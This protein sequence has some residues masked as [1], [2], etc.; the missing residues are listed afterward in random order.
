MEEEPNSGKIPL[1]PR[2]SKSNQGGAQPHADSRSDRLWVPP[3]IQEEGI[4]LNP[5]PARKKSGMPTRESLAA[6]GERFA[7]RPHS[8]KKRRDPRKR[9]IVLVFVVVLVAF[10]AGMR[11]GSKPQGMAPFAPVALN[12]D[13]AVALEKYLREL[14]TGNAMDALNGMLAIEERNPE[15]PS[16]AYL[17]S[18][19][20]LKAGNVT[21]AE[22][23]AL[24]SI[25]K[26]ERV[27]D[28]LALLAVVDPGKSGTRLGDPNVRVEEWL[29]KAALA[30]P[31]NPRPPLELAGVLRLQ[32]RNDEARSSLEASRARLTP[33][34]S[35]AAVLTTLALL[36]LEETPDDNLP[37][38]IRVRP[39]PTSLFASAY[40]QMRKGNHASAA[41]ILR[42]AKDQ[43]PEQIFQYLLGDPA[44]RKFDRFPEY[45]GLF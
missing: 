14:R 36:D 16:L 44:L 13:D 2:K 3:G 39:D 1:R 42:E 10:L 4:H 27:S 24:E 45:D 43:M 23:K 18:L 7:S 25:A 31:A 38:S 21:L 9:L 37:V 12:G 6:S 17:S 41:A 20:A 28:S 15:T 5:D 33:V 26:R 30:D 22:E 11:L 8:A 29:Q 34:D 40:L 32:R 19:A 35:E